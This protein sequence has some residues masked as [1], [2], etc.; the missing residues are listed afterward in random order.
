MNIKHTTFLVLGLLACFQ[1]VQAEID[2]KH[3]QQLTL[4]DLGSRL[5]AQDSV[6]PRRIQIRSLDQSSSRDME[7]IEGSSSSCGYL[8]LYNGI[9]CASALM[10]P[11]SKGTHL[12][13]LSS[14]IYAASLFGSYRSPWRMTIMQERFK[15]TARELF[16]K[17]VLQLL[18][19]PAEASKE[20]YEYLKCVIRSLDPREVHH[21]E[22]WEDGFRYH[23]NKDAVYVALYDRMATIVRDGT[24][25]TKV[26][27]QLTRSDLDKYF[28]DLVVD[29][30]ISFDGNSYS[31]FTPDVSL[32][33]VDGE[34]YGRWVRTTEMPH[35]IKFVKES[36]LLHNAPSL[37]IDTYGEDR[38]DNGEH[39]YA[40]E[41]LTKL[42]THMRSTKTDCMGIILMYVSPSH[43][44]KSSLYQSPLRSLCSWLGSWFSSASVESTTYKSD[45]EAQGTH[46]YGHWISLV[47]S[48]LNGSVN[49]YICDSLSN[50]N[51]LRD[52][53]V[54]EIID[55][56][57]GKKELPGYD[58]THK[59]MRGQP[60]KVC[61][62]ESH[63]PS[64]LVLPIIMGTGIACAL[65]YV[66]YSYYKKSKSEKAKE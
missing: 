56:L 29:F 40:T 1:G 38:T 43:F 13:N 54:N 6:D 37:I 31:T 15:G 16:Q 10:L 33:K 49:Y 2:L 45:F 63:S 4:S 46:D 47:V 50:I 14:T 18:A 19:C 27:K 51:R 42:Y 48:R 41:G 35:F 23:A 20:D 66:A 32:K 24:S 62:S 53:H 64:R 65:S 30:T 44:K 7:G 11:T 61:S 39:A 26:R 5:V 28:K 3:A 17:Q 57:D 52:P 59:E 25:A 55:I 58:C 8:A 21:P 9:L 36:N 60:S 34:Q 22:V 12:S